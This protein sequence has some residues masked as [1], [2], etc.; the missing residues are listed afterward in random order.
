M[1]DFLLFEST[2]DASTVQAYRDTEYRVY[3]DAP[4]TL[5]VGQASAALS[6]AH[7]RHRVDC[8]AYL[9]A[10][11]PASHRLDDAANAQRHAALGRELGQRSL[12]SLPGVG[13]H[14]SNERPGEASYLA[15]GLSL[16]A[17]RTLGT[18]LEQNAIVWIGADAVPQLILLR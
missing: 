17:A 3:G 13:C 7:R 6:A 2:V 8:S 18:R 9:S 11:N 16:Q 12:V 15:F 14:P 5:R 4:F 10:C 1:E